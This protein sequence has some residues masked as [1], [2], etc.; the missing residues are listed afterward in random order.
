MHSMDN[1]GSGQCHGVY[2]P[3]LTKFV[4]CI[5]NDRGCGRPG[6]RFLENRWETVLERLKVTNSRKP[7]QRIFFQRLSEGHEQ[8]YSGRQLGQKKKIGVVCK[9]NNNSKA[10]NPCVYG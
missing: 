6:L 5:N 8:P 4:I 9:N 7:M 3:L 1:R 2:A 10:Q